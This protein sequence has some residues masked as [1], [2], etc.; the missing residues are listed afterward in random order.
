MRTL[1]GVER[2][3]PLVAREQQLARFGVGF[4]GRAVQMLVRAALGEAQADVHVAR[5]EVGDAAQG[6]ECLA[7]LPGGAGRVRDLQILRA[8]FDVEPLLLVEHRKVLRHA[9]RLRIQAQSFLVDG[10]G[11]ERESLFAVMFGDAQ[12]TPD[13]LLRLAEARVEVAERVERGEILRL[14]LDD[15]AVLLDGLRNLVLRQTLLSRVDSLGF[16]E[17]HREL[18]FVPRRTM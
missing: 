10:D 8:G 16:I 9:R 15:L 4:G 12:E 11:F 13:R 6:F 17:S 18:T 14:V 7:R 2:L 1:V 5:V 3:L